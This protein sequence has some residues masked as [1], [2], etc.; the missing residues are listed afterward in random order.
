MQA[1]IS[2]IV[3]KILADESKSKEF[4]S[5]L[6]ASGRA[7]GESM[8]EVDGKKYIIRKTTSVAKP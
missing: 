8:I 4:M 2:S 3:K 1:P 7:T 6:L 5:K